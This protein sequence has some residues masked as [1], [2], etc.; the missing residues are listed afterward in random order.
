MSKHAAIMLRSVFVTANIG[1]KEKDN[2]SF[3]V[4][5]QKSE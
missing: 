3:V 4:L 1:I 2:Q 5:F